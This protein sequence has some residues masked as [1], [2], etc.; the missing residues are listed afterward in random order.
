M[1][2]IS[3]WPGRWRR[4]SWTTPGTKGDP[5][6][7]ALWATMM[8]MDLARDEF[9]AV[10]KELARVIETGDHF[11]ERVCRFLYWKRRKDGTRKLKQFPLV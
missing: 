2:R 1:S 5:V 8:K 4:S 7:S 3:D 6:V 11:D 9:Y 10:V